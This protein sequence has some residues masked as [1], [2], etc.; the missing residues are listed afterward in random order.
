[1]V[2]DICGLH[3]QVMSSAELA[4]AVRT[5]GLGRGTVS[6]ALWSARTLVKT[7]AMR[8]TLHL[9]TVEDYPLYVAALS[10]RRFDLDGP[11]LKYHGLVARDVPALVD[12]VA[13]AL[14]GRQLTR[15]ELGREVVRLL[16][17]GKWESLLASGWGAVLKPVAFQG[18]LCFGPSEG[19]RVSFV[20]P[21]QWLGAFDRPEPVASLTAVARRFLAAYGPATVEEFA[22]W[23]GVQPKAVRGV[24]GVENGFTPVTVEGG[25]PAWA[26]PE[27]PARAGR[28]PVVRLLPLFDPYTVA[29]RRNGQRPLAG[30]EKDLVYRKAGWISPVLLVDGELAGVWEHNED[31]DGLRIDIR[32]F[33]PVEPQ[34]GELATAEGDRLGA[35]FGI[36]ADITVGGFTSAR[37]RKNLRRSSTRREAPA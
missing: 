16:G 36:S 6:G 19:N 22:R 7:W 33:A 27:T 37:E 21:D 30:P 8:G 23:W 24:L 25:K 14:D 3:A 35:Y 2:G 18:Q 13:G 31:K 26:V 17:D 28:E 9:I 10:N 15:E 20:R 4:A 1:M 34:I 11:W 32:P 5:E 29:V 12:A